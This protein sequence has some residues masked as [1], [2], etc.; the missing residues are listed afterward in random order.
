MASTQQ[1]NT[2]NT[3]LKQDPMDEDLFAKA[4]TED[5]A[6]AALIISI[7][8]AFFMLVAVIVWMVRV[9]KVPRAMRAADMRSQM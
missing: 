9:F 4:D 8:V 1:Y 2:R 3:I 7:V 5:I 6:L